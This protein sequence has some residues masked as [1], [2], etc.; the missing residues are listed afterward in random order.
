M[1]SSHITQ[2]ASRIAANTTLVSEYLEAKH[3]PFPSF[4]LDGPLDTLIPKEEITVEAARVAI[5]DDTEELRRLVLGPREHLMSFAHHAL[6]SQQ[7][8]VRFKLAHSF[9]VGGEASFAELASASGLT[10]TTTRQLVRY[11]ITDGIF[12]EP[13]RG[14]VAHNA[15]S[16]LLVEDTVIL[17]WVGTAADGGWQAASRI[18]DALEQFPG[19]EEPNETGYALAH[20]TDKP[21]Y[22]F[23]S[24]HPDKARRFANTMRAFT[25]GTGYELS[26]IT[27]NFPWGG[28]GNGV[29]VDVGGSAGHA[30]IAIARKF[31]SVSCVV[32]DFAPVVE[33][34][35]NT[36][37][38]EL[39]DRVKLEVHDFMTEQPVKNADVYFFRWIFHNWSDK[40]SIKILR[41]LIPALKT[42][43]KIV[44][45]DNVLPEPGML[46]RWQERHLRSMD[47]TQMMIQNAHE[48]ELDDWKNLFEKADARF[49][50]QWAKQPQGSTLWFLV[51]EWTGND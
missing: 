5:I 6:L 32:Q 33:S 50:F 36:V 43:A 12:T 42:G 9:P 26:H 37:P 44:V 41:N 35:S 8:I 51:F 11:A 22:E 29:V 24:T 25:T 18:C 7:A 20:N 47:L 19:S 40:Y 4:D 1:S 38:A 2:L 15:V 34:F 16:R 17:D 49:Q 14:M 31:P 30:S 21:I 3:L 13:K 45:N 28:L 48:R 23:L 46:S 10:E 39:S 27:D